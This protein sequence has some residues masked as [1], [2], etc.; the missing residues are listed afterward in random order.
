MPGYSHLT[1]LERDRIA[2]LKAQGLGAEI[3][4]KR[5]KSDDLKTQ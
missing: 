4:I 1:R 2:E 3:A 5:E